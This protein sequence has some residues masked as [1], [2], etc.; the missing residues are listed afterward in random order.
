M[1]KYKRSS[2]EMAADDRADSEL[3]RHMSPAQKA[4]W[5]KADSQMDSGRKMSAVQDDRAD[6]RLAAR[7]KRTVK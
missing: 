6:R 7:I 4:A 1:A 5:K 2:G 3:M